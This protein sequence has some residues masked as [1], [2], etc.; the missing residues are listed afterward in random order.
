MAVAAAA[1]R[2][3]FSSDPRGRLRASQTAERRSRTATP[4]FSLP[5]ANNNL[6]F[7][8]REQ[9][10]PNASLGTDAVDTTAANNT[11]SYS[12][13]ETFR[14]TQRTNAVKQQI[15][16]QVGLN[17]DRQHSND[18]SMDLE[19]LQQEEAASEAEF[20][21]R[22]QA[23]QDR[24][25]SSAKRAQLESMASKSLDKGLQFLGEKAAKELSAMGINSL[26]DLLEILD[27][28]EDLFVFQIINGVL[29][30]GKVVRAIFPGK[31]AS[32]DNPKNL[33]ELAAKNAYTLL[34]VI[35]PPVGISSG[36]K[37]SGMLGALL[38]G[39]AFSFMFLILCFFIL[40]IYGL[41][42]FTQNPFSTL[43][44]VYQAGGLSAAASAVNT[45][46]NAVLDTAH[47]NFTQ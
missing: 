1:M 31:L 25:L 34:D 6:G 10:P 12:R 4:K 38:Y 5:A 45:A 14:R 35:F 37:I 36:S 8:S 19:D 13:D 20:L 29:D 17:L 44:Q 46:G 30:A 3:G 28:G 32:S 22:N 11:N 16:G 39:L 23:G 40:V 7:L 15:G 47:Q 24:R 41:I 2:P 42:S 26:E 9:F 27:Y 33:K 18:D 21:E 43:F